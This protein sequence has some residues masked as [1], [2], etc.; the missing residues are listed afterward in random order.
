VLFITKA[1]L[2]VKNYNSKPFG[3]IIGT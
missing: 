3:A 2:V 1:M